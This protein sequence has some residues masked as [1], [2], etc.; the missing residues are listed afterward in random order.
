MGQHSLLETCV[1]VMRQPACLA[2]LV[3]LLSASGVNGKVV[4]YILS[5]ANNCEKGYTQIDMQMTTDE[6]ALPQ[7]S[8]WTTLYNKT[9]VTTKHRAQETAMGVFSIY[10]SL[11]LA[12][13]TG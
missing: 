6:C 10:D 11:V 1:V 4:C 3:I 8:Q 2:A 13:A 5:T 9:K 12:N 7:W